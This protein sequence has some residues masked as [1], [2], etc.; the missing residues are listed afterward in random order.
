MR[1]SAHL[2]RVAD[3]EE[4]LH[5]AFEFLGKSV[6][7]A[8]AQRKHDCVRVHSALLLVLYSLY[9]RALLVD[10]HE[11][12][13]KHEFRARLLQLGHCVV[14]VL[15]PR[16]RRDR[17]RHFD[18]SQ[19]VALLREEFAR[20]E[21]RHT[22]AD[23]GD[24][25]A[26]EPDG[27]VKDLGGG[28]DVC[29]VR[30]LDRSRTQR[31]RTRGDYH[32]VRIE[33]ENVRR[34]RFRAK[35]YFRAE[36][37]GVCFEILCAPADLLLLRSFVR[38]VDLTAAHVLFLEY[39]GF[40]TAS[41]EDLRSR[42]SRDSAAD[43][44]NRSSLTVG[45]K[46]VEPPFLSESGIDG[47]ASVFAHV[48]VLHH[49]L[50]AVKAIYTAFDLVCSA[51]L[52]LLRPMRIRDM[53]SAEGHEVLYAALKLLL[54]LFRR[55]DDVGCKHG[56]IAHRFLDSFRHVSAPAAVE[57][58]RLQPVVVSVVRGGRYVYSVHAHIS[59]RLGVFHAGVQSVPLSGLT[60]LV[61][62]FVN[63]KADYERIIPAASFADA[64]D[65]L[66]DEA[67][68]VLEAAAVFVRTLV[69]VG[70]EEL[71]QQIS[72]G[73]M[74]LH[75]VYSRFLAPYRRV[76]E[77]LDEFLYLAVRECPDVSARHLAGLAFGR[78]GRGE[79]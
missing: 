3:N 16:P 21:P 22:G 15:E 14:D 25:F 8:R 24:V 72:V 40:E 10:G 73:G 1:Y 59:E 28:V 38:E 56:Q 66:L 35:T 71:L 48:G 2:V 63:G 29:A 75:T 65:D 76:D 77:L 62:A 18:E 50:Y 49:T 57:R 36:L 46:A 55:T 31:D 7:G 74:E 11:L 13:G 6:D 34:R 4:V 12:G 60:D 20:F 47:T 26:F 52:R 44:R 9:D 53:R 37:A 43:Y 41:T 78:A 64:F 67:H 23:E 54:R 42:E 79:H 30:A 33:R 39:D 45:R 70:A 69:G 68:P 19:L 5:F 32:R 61:I 58:S 17:I 27:A 51:G